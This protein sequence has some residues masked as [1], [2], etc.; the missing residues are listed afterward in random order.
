MV[1]FVLSRF[2]YCESLCGVVV[3]H[4]PLLDWVC[5]TGYCFPRPGSTRLG[6]WYLG[7]AFRD[8]WTGYL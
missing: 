8:Y 6:V 1:V 5:G 3:S 2:V 4:R 7:S